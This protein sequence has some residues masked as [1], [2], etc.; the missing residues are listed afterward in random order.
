MAQAAAGIRWDRLRLRPVTLIKAGEDLL[1]ERAIDRYVRLARA[2]DPNV[3]TV[4]ISPAAYAEHDLDVHAS[5]SLFGE[6]KLLLV[7]H[8]EDADGT[9]IADL[10][11][12]V[13]QPQPD[14]IMLIVHYGSQTGT[15][16]LRDIARIGH[17]ICEIPKAKT[18]KDKRRLIDEEAIHREG[19]IANDAAWALIEALGSD[20]RELLSA[21]DQLFDDIE[22]PVTIEHVREYYGGRREA[23][24][25]NVADAAIAG[26]TGDAIALARHA[27]ATGT[28]HVRIVAALAD[29]LRDIALAKDGK[30]GR[31]RGND[32]R[33]RK[34]KESARHWS[35]QGL[36]DAILAVVQADADIKGASR[37]P[38]FA[39]ERALI[40]IGRA[41]RIRN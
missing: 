28:N 14:C 5:P 32:W 25:Y 12:Y 19:A 38:D 39:V 11:R 23:T 37:D 35:D 2:H 40:L 7:D 31:G 30:A 13:A 1:A 33:M 4:R 26:Q 10:R 17:Q 41:R 21:L 36:G 9:L 22:G 15:G 24:G 16:L 3:E 34:A 6:A 8:A 18:G 27:T 20:T 29:K